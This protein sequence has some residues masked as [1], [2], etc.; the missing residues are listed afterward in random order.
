[1]S[2]E[3]CRLADIA[4]IQGGY[5]FKS[6]DFGDE[7]VAVVK[8]ANIKP[9]MVSLDGVDRVKTDKLAGLDRFRLKDGDVLMAMTGATVGKVGRFKEREPA[10]LNQ[11]VARISARHGKEYDDFIC[12][13]VSQP[14][15]DALIEGASAGSAQANISATGI[16]AV[17]IPLLDSKEQLAI[18]QLARALDDR[19]ALLRETNATLEAIAQ[20]LFKSWFVDF[21]PV[22]DKLEGRTPEG[23]D[24]ATAALFPDGFESSELGEVPRGWVA[25]QL[26]DAV[27]TI[28]SGG[29]PD[30]RCPEFW[31]GGIPWFSSGETRNSFVTRTEKTITQ[32]GVAGSSTRAA[33]DGDVLIASAG[34]GHTRGQTSFCAIDCYIN[35]SVVAVRAGQRSMS[36]WLFYNLK[37]RYEEMRNLSDSHSSRGSLTTKLLGGMPIL[38]PPISVLT[39]FN[40]TVAVLISSVVSNELQAENLAILRDT[41]LP[42]LISGQLRLP[43]AQAQLKNAIV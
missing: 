15:F 39:A 29:T 28:F 43:E 23:M 26:A 21:D 25:T 24:E 9:P 42:R 8:I 40:D 6:A 32:A 27:D 16:G 11:R 12:A 19:I 31:G 14:G 20:A 37:G 5:A 4:L 3:N 7:G 30:T 41:L 38:A 33:R 34:Q 22:R 18:G 10:Y 13:V 17:S 1:M 2:S 36:A 35:Q